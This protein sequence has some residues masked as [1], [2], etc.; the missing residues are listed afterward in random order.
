MLPFSVLR[1]SGLA[2]VTMAVQLDTRSAL[3]VVVSCRCGQTSGARSVHSDTGVECARDR[4]ACVVLS[5][6]SRAST[7][8]RSF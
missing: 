3:V 5:C 2:L 7:I 6:F 4:I 1:W 8:S